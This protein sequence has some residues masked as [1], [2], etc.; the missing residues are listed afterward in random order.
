MVRRILLRR[1]EESTFDVFKTDFQICFSSSVFMHIYMGA[2]AEQERACSSAW[3][4]S[5]LFACTHSMRRL[6]LS[7]QQKHMN[8]P[9]SHN[10]PWHYSSVA[11]IME[12]SPDHTLNIHGLLLLFKHCNGSCPVSFVGSL[13]LWI[14][15]SANLL[16]RVFVFSSPQQCARR[17]NKSVCHK[18]KRA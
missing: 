7:A 2:T 18:Y 5:Y 10:Q 3:N 6:I 1:G 17:N 16:S 13:Q 9:C 12:V 14:S 11:H 8:H 15:C 4:D